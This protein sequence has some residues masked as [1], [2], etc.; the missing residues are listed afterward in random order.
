[1]SDIH[2]ATYINFQGHA[3][4]ALEF[5]QRALGGEVTLLAMDEQGQLRPAE[6]DERVAGGRLVAG[7]VV[8]LGSD[9]HPSYPPTVGENIAIALLGSDRERLTQAFDAL[10]EGGKVKA[11]LSAPTPD[12]GVGWF[13]DKFGLNWMVSVEPA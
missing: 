11:K 2:T 1:M 3:R 5:Y 12:S 7:G 4:E 10:S 9:G 13:E 6:A 8:I